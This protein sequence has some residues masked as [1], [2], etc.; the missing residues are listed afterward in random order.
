MTERDRGTWNQQHTSWLNR[1]CRSASVALALL[2][3]TSFSTVALGALVCALPISAAFAQISVNAADVSALAGTTASVPISIALP[4]GTPCANLAFTLTVVANGGAPAVSSN[5]TFASLVGSPSA[6]LNY[7]PATV[8]VGWFSNFS[9]V[10]TGTAQVG[11]LSVPIPAGAV[12]GQ[13]YTVQVINPFATSDGSTDLGNIDSGNGSITVG[14]PTTPGVPSATTTTPPARP[15]PTTGGGGAVCGNGITESGEDCDDGGTCV[16]GGNAG[17][18]CIAESDC[19][20]NGVCIGGTMAST[21]CAAASDCPG[22]TCQDCVPQGGHGCA[23]NCTTETQVVMNLQ[24]GKVVNGTLAPGTSGSIVWTDTAL[25]A[26]VLPFQTGTTQT[27]AVGKARNGLIPLVVLAASVS[28]PKID[29]SGLACACVRGVDDM[30]CGGYL[31]EATGDCSVTITQACSQNTDCPSGETCVHTLATDCTPGYNPGTCSGTSPQ[32]CSADTDCPTVTLPDQSTVQ[33]CE[34]GV[35]VGVC[36]NCRVDSDCS[37]L[38]GGTCV[39]HA[40]DGRNPC[41]SVNGTGNSGSGFIDCAAG[42]EGVN[43]LFT[44][45]SGGSSEPDIC[46]PALGGPDYVPPSP[47]YP[48]CGAPPVITL[49]G[50]G[51]AGS[52]VV[53]DTTAI[54]QA[55]GPCTAQGTTFCTNADTYSARGAPETL[56]SVTGIAEGIIYN[57]DQTDG[58]NICNCPTGLTGCDISECIVDAAHPNGG[59]SMLGTVLP[60]GSTVCSQVP[61]PSITGL[62]IAGAFTS[63]SNNT[64]DDEVVTNLL[65]SE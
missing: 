54:G 19:Q 33:N 36:A 58:E 40:C 6:N 11:T 26:L 51:P 23:A 55:V 21:A 50:T 61:A 25:G 17:T 60:S 44:E 64:T 9:P 48:L 38:G 28:F 18:P 45:V 42:L 15:T 34:G 35:G 65:L 24:P 10:L 59:I 56:P 31:T 53:L 52:A 32:S 12:D 7:G 29:V 41:T 8:L 49:Y 13:T 1:A 3:S 20:G 47:A 43:L 46:N 63:L 22:G 30:T 37:G 16:G 57:D 62:G 2:A 4:A 14:T 5:A 39:M 27:L